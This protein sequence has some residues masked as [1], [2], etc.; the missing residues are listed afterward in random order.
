MTVYS[1]LFDQLFYIFVRVTSLSL[2]L[3]C[4]KDTSNFN[5]LVLLCFNGKDKVRQGY[6]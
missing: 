5:L 2:F 3:F 6:F 4:V 1:L